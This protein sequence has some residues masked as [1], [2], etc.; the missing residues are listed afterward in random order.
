[1]IPICKYFQGIK[2]YLSE[3]NITCN[4]FSEY[5]LGNSAW[6]QYEQLHLLSERDL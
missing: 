4:Y 2:P 5:Q 1:M 3:S 6:I